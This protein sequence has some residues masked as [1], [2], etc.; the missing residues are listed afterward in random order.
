MGRLDRHLPQTVVCREGPVFIA[1]GAQARADESEVIRLLR[2]HPNP[3]G[4]KT[5][6]QPPKAENAIKREI[7]RVELDVCDGVQQRGMTVTAA[8]APPR[9]VL[10]GDQQRGFRPPRLGDR[11]RKIVR[12]NRKTTGQPVLA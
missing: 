1:K 5:F 8:H 3:A 4:V 6:R 12:H 11:P 2:G 10:R 7:D 9:H